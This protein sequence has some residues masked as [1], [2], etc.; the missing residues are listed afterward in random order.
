MRFIPQQEHTCHVCAHAFIVKTE[1]RRDAGELLSGPKVCPRCG[2]PLRYSG[3]K[4]IGAAKNLVLTHYGLDTYRNTFG[5]AVEFFL[6]HSRTDVDIEDYLAL[7]ARI[8]FAEWERDQ[9][10]AAARRGLSAAE[11]AEHRIVPTA[12][13]DAAAGALQ[14][15]LRRAAD[16]AKAI[17]AE[18]RARHYPVR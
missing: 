5:T 15:A 17:L 4:D 11:L 3:G 16:A 6:R 1:F 9:Q 10:R 2:V 18:E 14:A 8:D 13:A 7:V 12:R